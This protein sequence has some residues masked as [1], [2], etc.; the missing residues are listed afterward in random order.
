MRRRWL[1]VTVATLIVLVLLERLLVDAHPE[2]PWAGIP[3]FFVLFGF[4]GCLLIIGLAKLL[5]HY[6]L[7]REEDYYRKADDDADE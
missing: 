1:L 4:L 7:L 6:W 3:G 5:G 2:L